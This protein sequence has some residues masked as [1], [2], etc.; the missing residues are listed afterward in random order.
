LADDS[1]HLVELRQVR[2]VHGFVPKHAIDREETRGLEA[3][4]RQLVQAAR[5]H[6][7][8]V[9]AKDVL[10]RL[11]ALPR[12][13][14]PDGAVPPGLV[15][16]SY[17]LDVVLR[18]LV[19]ALRRLKEERVVRIACR[20]HLRLDQRVEVPESALHEVVRRHLRET[21]L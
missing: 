13:L 14:V 19:R 16:G 7:G 5:G 8:G 17:A 6:G 11:R 2:A 1:L 12:V 18:S 4:L 3:V 15:H 21:K 20:M 10:V 9:R